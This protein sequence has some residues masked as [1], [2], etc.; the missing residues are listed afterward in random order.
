MRCTYVLKGGHFAC[1]QCLPCRI[2]IRREKTHR[3]MLEAKKHAHSSFLTLTYD[4]AH[5]PPF[6]SLSPRDFQLWLKRFRLALGDTRLRFFGV[7]EYGELSRRPHY[8]AA[9]FGV[10]ADALPLV[11]ATWKKCD[12]SRATLEPLV[13]ERAQY[14]AGYV[15]KKMTKKSD[16]RLDG[17]EPEFMRCSLKPGIA[18]TAVPDIAASLLTNPH[19]VAFLRQE[20]D[21][22]TFLKTA[23]RTLPTGRY[24]RSKLRE[25]LGYDLSIAGKLRRQKFI[26]EKEYAELQ[27]LYEATGTVA[28]FFEKKQGFY[29]SSPEE[30]D[31]KVDQMALNLD[32]RY[33]LNK[34]RR[35]I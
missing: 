20:G 18:A 3:I 4:D 22:P 32:A 1:R 8:H 14:L 13:V 5:L 26:S 2:A 33:R 24:F 34:K 23:G 19:A 6:A 29:T 31:Q 11:H 10:G 27:A 12:P 21:V 16:P 30:R 7:G 9:L 15:T 35:R 28:A 17:R 25:Q